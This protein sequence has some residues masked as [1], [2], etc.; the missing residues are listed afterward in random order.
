MKKTALFI[1]SMAINLSIWAQNIKVTET[2][3]R[4]GDGV[5]PAL[6]VYVYECKADEVEKEWKSL[7]K[8]YKSEKV[9]SKDGVTADNI[10]IPSITDG[11]MDVYA[12]A[13]KIKDNEVKFIVAFDLGGA[14]LSSSLNNSKAYSEASRMLNDFARKT[15]KNAVAEKLK[16]AQ[17]ALDKLKD[18]Q[19]ELEEKNSDLKKDIENYKDKIKK[20]EDDIADNKNNQEKKKAE[21]ESQRKLVDEIAIKE[22][23]I[24]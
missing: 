9:S 22:K 21:I 23:N 18:Q 7:M 3:E 13:E 11:T 2:T 24:N 10:V 17:K 5:H 1:A 6:V 12:R 8:D 20:A 16:D 19:K 15:S 14:Y 4:I